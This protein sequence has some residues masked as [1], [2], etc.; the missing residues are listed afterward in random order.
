MLSVKQDSIK[1]HFLSLWYDSTWDWT[2]IS[3]PIG[4]HS[5][6]YTKARYIIYN[7]IIY[8]LNIYPSGWVFSNGPEDRGSV[9]LRVLPKTQKWYLVPTCLTLS[10]ITYRSRENWSNP[11]NGVAPSPTPWCREG[12]NFLIEKGAFRSPS[13]KVVNFT[14]LIYNIIISII[15]INKNNKNNNMQ[16]TDQWVNQSIKRKYHRNMKNLINEIDR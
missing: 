16:S 11:V 10:I 5:N 3:W 6:H 4:E 15:I 7:I 9:P 12:R 14:F 13:S 1:Y 8:R 2:Q